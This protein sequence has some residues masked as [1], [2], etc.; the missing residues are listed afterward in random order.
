MWRYQLLVQAVLLPR[1]VA[2]EV[3]AVVAVASSPAEVRLHLVCD[4]AM[5]VSILLGRSW[6]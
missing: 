1:V 4:F 3:V 5:H 6:F 2:F